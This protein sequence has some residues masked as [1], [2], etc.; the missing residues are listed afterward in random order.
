MRRDSL[1]RFTAIAL[2]DFPLVSSGDDLARIIVETARQNAVLIEDGDLIVAAQ[3]IFSKAEGRVVTLRKI[4]PS[5][6]A[7]ELAEA[8]GKSPRFVEL[9]LGESKSILKASRDILLVKDQRGLVCINAGI[10]KSNVEGSGNFA[11]LPENPDA[12]AENCRRRIKELTGKNVALIICDTYSRPFRRGQVNFA[13][14]TAGV[15][16]FK[17]YRGKRDLFGQVL[18][19]K[20]VAIVDEIAAA[21]ELLMGQAEEA[22]P[23]VFFKGLSNV[24]DFCEKCGIADLQISRKEDLFRGAL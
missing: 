2:E 7:K 1:K 21:A 24:V 8:I 9:V 23:V 15:K 17:D 3:K 14:G 22:R 6:K 18:K 10:D 19:V 5:G 11:L 13:I 12:S 20:N 16:L 4:N